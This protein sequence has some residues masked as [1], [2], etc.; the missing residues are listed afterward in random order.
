MVDEESAPER[1]RTSRAADD[2]LST[3]ALNRALLARQMLLQREPLSVVDAVE[4]LVGMQAQ[5]PWPPYYGLWSR[6]STFNA[7]DLGNALVNREVVRIVLQRGTIHLV[8]AADVYRLRPVLQGMLERQFASSLWVRN[9]SGVDLPAL[10]A[11]GCALLAEQPLT[12]ADLGAALHAHFPA[13]DPDSLAQAVRTYAPLVQVPPR[14]VWGQGGLARH[15]TV[16]TWLGADISHDP[17]DA[18]PDAVILRYLAAFGP[19]S[20]RDMQA[21]SKL[22]RL[23]VAV[24]RLRPQ[25]VTF[26]DDLGVELFDLPDAPRPDPDTPAPVRFLPDFDNVLLAYADRRRMMTDAQRAVIF[27][28]NGLI[29]ATV[30]VDGFT[31]ALWRLVRERRTLTLVIE[32]FT[33]APFSAAVVDEMQAEGARLL[34]FAAE[35]GDA[36][37]LRIGPVPRRM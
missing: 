18:V 32:P 26:R 24:E 3:C 33:P 4:R 20:V 29:S 21:W 15:T 8:S 22:T 10:I 12:F 25:L 14:A 16:D 11:T 34:A 9:L 2:I 7:A 30:T 31:A 19:A 23:K 17:A 6:L 27:S 35:E 13:H 1:R 37:D 36:V 28:K 5:A